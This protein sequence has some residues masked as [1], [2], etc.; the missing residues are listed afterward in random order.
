MKNVL[1]AV[2]IDDGVYEGFL[3][4]PMITQRLKIDDNG[5]IIRDDTSPYNSHGTQVSSIIYKNYKE[6]SFISIKVLDN[7]GSGEIDTLIAALT[8]CLKNDVELI[9]MSI[10]TSNYYDS[11]PL[12]KVIKKLVGKGVIIISAFDNYNTKSFPACFPGI[13]G[14]R[15]GEKS[16]ADDGQY[17]FDLDSG[18][19]LE[20]SIIAFS[21]TTY[22]ANSFAAPII[23]A[24]IFRYL[25]DRKDYE[26]KG[27]L[28]YLKGNSTTSIIRKRKLFDYHMFK[29]CKV[30]I[31]VIGVS[32]ELV[33]EIEQ[34]FSDEGYVSA[35]FSSSKIPIS[36]YTDGEIDNGLVYVLMKIFTPG[37]I[38]FESN[39]QKEVFDACLY[40]SKNSYIM[41]T[42]EK[43][44]EFTSKKKLFKGVEKYFS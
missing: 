3:E 5:E 35:C 44:Q 14:V 21:S 22:Q 6:A 36:Y 1:K 32:S 28:E 15:S 37:L 8:W 11:F 30:D 9:H 4:I 39:C 17:S 41:M 23:T 26:F 10:G 42:K 13:F 24:A 34:Y 25:E 43:N 33:L 7:E 29:D 40:R 27:I 19:P 2:I 31:P 20:N 18:M 12:S 38:I 16:Q